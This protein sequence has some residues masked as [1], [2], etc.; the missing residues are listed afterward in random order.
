VGEKNIAGGGGRKELHDSG[1]VPKKD[2]KK[3]KTENIR[4]EEIPCLLLRT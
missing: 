4:K 2:G 3:K 1:Y